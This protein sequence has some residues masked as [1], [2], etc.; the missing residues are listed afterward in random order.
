MPARVR[1][2]LRRRE[3]PHI[4]VPDVPPELVRGAE[5]AMLREE[6]MALARS[7]GGQVAFTGVI[8]EGKYILGLAEKDS[9]GYRPVVWVTEE[10][11]LIGTF[12]SYDA[13]SEFAEEMNEELGLTKTEAVRIVL[14]TMGRR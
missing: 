7:M 2:H 12:P 10:G 13:A 11:S 1:R 14:S 6:A 9:P 8:H 3:S 5:R 4:R